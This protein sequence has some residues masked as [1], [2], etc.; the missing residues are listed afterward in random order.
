MTS[1]NGESGMFAIR[2]ARAID[3]EGILP[4]HNDAVANTTAVW[5]E[6]QVDLAN[7]QA[8]IADRQAAGFP[9]LVAIAADGGVLG[10]AA[11]GDWR[12]WSGYRHTVEHSVYVRGDQRGRGVGVALMERLIDRA[13]DDGKHV[14]IAGIEA[15]NRASIRLH[16]RLGFAEVGRMREVGA[17][18]GTW[19]DL[20]FMQLRLDERA[21]PD[22]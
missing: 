14:M 22:G 15:G 2:D 4:I 17:K 8:W 13:R 6:V 19:L 10:Y 20:V 21:A 7:R 3:A 12:A 5:N 16:E 18:F 9:I 11:Y 1:D